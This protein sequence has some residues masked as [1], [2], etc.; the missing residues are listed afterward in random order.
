MPHEMSTNEV[1][2]GEENDKMVEQRR[3]VQTEEWLQMKL[4]TQH[5]AVWNECV[6]YLILLAGP[7]KL[8]ADILNLAYSRVWITK[9]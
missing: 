1:G 9:I 2:Q 4:Q 6:G 3:C 8:R 7:W 5:S